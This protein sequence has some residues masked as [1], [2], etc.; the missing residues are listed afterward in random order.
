MKNFYDA[1]DIKPRLKLAVQLTLSP[2][3][4]CYCIVTING[5]ELFSGV[6]KRTTKLD[7][8]ADLE[9]SIDFKIAVE[10]QHPQAVV[11]E[12]IS[13][14]G[15]SIIPLYQ[16]RATPQTTYINFSGDWQLSIPSFYPWYHEVSGQGWIV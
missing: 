14:N 4:N 8:T 11:V 7:Y 1:I 3:D 6:L 13:I 2:V 5:T 16:H 15:H 10:R 12:D 9:E